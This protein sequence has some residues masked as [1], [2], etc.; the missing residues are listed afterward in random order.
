MSGFSTT[1]QLL[2]VRKPESYFYTFQKKIV[3]IWNF[4]FYYI[5]KLNGLK[6]SI[7]FAI[8]RLL[9]RVNTSQKD[10]KRNYNKL[11]Y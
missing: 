8:G 5:L 3:Q 2:L 1:I 6:K 10:L 7:V 9:L 4:C 11:K